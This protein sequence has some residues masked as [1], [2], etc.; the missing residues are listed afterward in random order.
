MNCTNKE[1]CT[2]TFHKGLGEGIIYPWERRGAHCV[3]GW[4]GPGPVWTGAGKLAPAGIRSSIRPARSQSLH[5]L[6][7]PGPTVPSTAT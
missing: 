3:R 7:Y 4:I 6:R 1:K 2:N 5:R